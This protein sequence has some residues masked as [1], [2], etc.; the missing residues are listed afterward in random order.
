M[1]CP[2]RDAQIEVPRSRCPNSD[3]RPF[4]R[5]IFSVTKPPPIFLKADGSTGTNIINLPDTNVIINQQQYP[6]LALE[7]FLHYTNGGKNYKRDN[8][9]NNP[10]LYGSSQWVWF[11][12]KNIWDLTWPICH[13]RS[14]TFP[15]QNISLPYQIHPLNNIDKLQT[16][17]LFQYTNQYKNKKRDKSRNLSGQSLTLGRSGYDHRGFGWVDVVFQRLGTYMTYVPIC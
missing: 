15:P 1:R 12:R 11:G 16:E 14:K 13:G 3:F 4:C 9:R 10:L 6:K 8:I 17:K 2:D 5:T 7:D